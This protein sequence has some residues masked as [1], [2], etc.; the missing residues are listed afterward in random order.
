MPLHCPPPPDFV[1]SSSFDK[2]KGGPSPHTIAL[3]VDELKPTST[4]AKTQMNRGRPVSPSTGHAKRA[5]SLSFSDTVTVFDSS[6]DSINES[7]VP[8]PIINHLSRYVK[9]AKANPKPY[10]RSGPSTFECRFFDRQ[11]CHNESM[12]LEDTQMS[13]DALERHLQ[14]LSSEAAAQ[15][16]VTMHADVEWRR[17]CEPLQ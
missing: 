12:N 16:V 14:H 8:P 1:R 17:M 3:T 11:L 9:R 13:N 15:A 2:D 6:D 4:L 10:R 7:V 5:R